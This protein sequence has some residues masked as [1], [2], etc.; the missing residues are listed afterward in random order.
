[1]LPL[2]GRT[3][4][5]TGGSRGIGRAIVHR[6]VDDGAYVHFIYHSHGQDS[7]ALLAEISIRGGKAFASQLYIGSA[8][9]IRR[10]FGVADSSLGGLDIVVHNAPR[11][12]S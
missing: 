11:R 1:M 9:D 12:T 7:E 4:L 8:Q 6:L 10:I 2:D 3:A 5:V